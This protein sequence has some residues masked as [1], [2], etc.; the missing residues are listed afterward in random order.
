MSEIDLSFELDGQPQD[1]N[2]DGN[3]SALSLL[4]EDLDQST[5]RPG[6]SPKGCVEAAQ[7]WS[8]ASFA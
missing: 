6:C 5:L 7:C 2:V 3:R 1:C 8:T 4:R